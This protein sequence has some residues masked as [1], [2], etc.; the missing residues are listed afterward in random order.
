VFYYWHTEVKDDQDDMVKE[1]IPKYLVG[2]ASDDEAQ[3]VLAWIAAAPENERHYQHIKKI[4]AVSDEY[5]AAKATEVLD[6]NI[7]QEWNHFKHTIAKGDS[8]PVIELR[9]TRSATTFN[10]YKIAAAL[11]MVAVSAFVIN[12]FVNKP[13]D[14]FHQTADN[15]L[16][17]VLPDGSQITL[18]RHSSLAYSSAFGDDER[19]VTLVGEGFFDVVRNTRK[20]FIIEVNKAKVEVLG[21][22]FNIRA[23]ETTKKVEVIVKTGVVRLSAPDL[24]TEIKLTAGEKGVF[25]LETQALASDVNKDVNFLSWNTRTLIFEENDLRTVIETIN[26]TYHTNITIA[27]DIPVSCVV[28]VSFDQQTLDAVL[29][30]LETTLNLT[31]KIN[32]NQ[33]EIISAGC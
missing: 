30:V 31:Y 14:I 10:W 21:T 1:L 2:E 18:N 22:S 28:T 17:V 26:K 5:Y 27:T 12:Y 24:K 8:N 16:S 15:T 9:S 11:L 3:A 29:N 23:Y 6:I 25:A 4:L 32:G 33:I 7:D 20:P 19:T 13:E